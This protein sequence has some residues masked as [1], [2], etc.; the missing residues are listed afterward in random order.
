MLY[1]FRFSDSPMDPQAVAPLPQGDRATSQMRMMMISTA[2]HSIILP[3]IILTTNIQCLSVNLRRCNIRLLCNKPIYKFHL[4]VN[5]EIHK[6]KKIGIQLF[7]ADMHS[8][9]KEAHSRKFK[10]SASAMA[11]ASHSTEPSSPPFVIKSWT[12]FSCTGPKKVCELVNNKIKMINRCDW[13]CQ[14]PFCF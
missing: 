14:M 4:S 2:K 1:L 13:N 11:S 9:D 3:C 8:I 10:S 5:I 6:H 12:A 7:K